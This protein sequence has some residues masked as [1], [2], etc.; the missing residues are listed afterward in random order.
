MHSLIGM[1]DNEND[2]Y[3][4]ARAAETAILGVVRT[5]LGSFFQLA[6]P[7]RKASVK[8]Q[9]KRTNQSTAISA[10]L[11]FG[12][13]MKP[14]LVRRGFAGSSPQQ[15]EKIAQRENRQS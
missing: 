8:A 12:L 3:H 10:L 11:S 15:H 5:P 1:H 9:P 7:I 14:C 6:C 2:T 13:T 4:M